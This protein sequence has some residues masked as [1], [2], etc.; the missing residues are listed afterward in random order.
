MQA[1]SALTHNI[2]GTAKACCQTLLAVWIYQDTKTW[3]WW[4]ANMTVLGGSGLYARVQQL[5]MEWN[6][7]KASFKTL[8]K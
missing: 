3:Q 6:H 2:S 7:K 8:P 4:I 5:E 1:T